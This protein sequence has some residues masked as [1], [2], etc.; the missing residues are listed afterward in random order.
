M[1]VRLCAALLQD[2]C[3]LW[4]YQADGFGWRFCNPLF[5]GQGGD[6]E[7]VG[8]V[9]R[10]PAEALCARWPI[11]RS[12]ELHPISGQIADQLAGR[13]AKTFWTA[14]QLG[15]PRYLT[16]RVLHL[17]TKPEAIRQAV[18]DWSRDDHSFVL[19]HQ[20]E[21]YAKL[22]AWL[23]KRRKQRRFDFVIAGHS[24]LARAIE[25]EDGS[26]Y[27]N[28][29]TWMQLIRLSPASLGQ[30]ERFQRIYDDLF[31]EKEKR[32]RL[33]E[34]AAHSDLIW[35]RPTVVR[36]RTTKKGAEG[37]LLLVKEKVREQ[38]SDAEEKTPLIE[39]QSLQEWPFVVAAKDGA[40]GGG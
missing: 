39:L 31:G 21:L 13:A 9:Q 16:D 18:R 35:N 40:E 19:T 1:Q 2:L 38:K 36:I 25:N 12:I 22:M 6:E 26:Y 7:V 32:K 17:R 15:I 8:Q 28:A 3:K 10:Q 37:E 14:Q 23:Q 34:L 24:H 11:H 27:F 4:A 29:G 33:S 20:D 5:G 30:Q